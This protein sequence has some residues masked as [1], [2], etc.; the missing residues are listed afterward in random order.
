VFGAILK[1][2]KPLGLEEP[3]PQLLPYYEQP[4]RP[5]R[6]PGCAGGGERSPSRGILVAD[7]REGHAFGPPEIELV[8]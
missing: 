8:T 4:R 7:R 5:R 1:E 3:R 2:R 6:L